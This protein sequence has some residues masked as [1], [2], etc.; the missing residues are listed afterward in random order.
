[1]DAIAEREPVPRRLSLDSGADTG[2]SKNPLRLCTGFP[3]RKDFCIG[4]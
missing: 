1:M 4:Y 3:S 2:Q